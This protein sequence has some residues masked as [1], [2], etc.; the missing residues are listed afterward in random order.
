MCR[1]D[2]AA[3]ADEEGAILERKTRTHAS[4]QLQQ[5]PGGDARSLHTCLTSFIGRR[6]SMVTRFCVQ[7]LKEDDMETTAEAATHRQQQ[8]EREIW[9]E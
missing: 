1:I 3:G 6:T 9:I 8:R 2:A 5:L 7:D 4:E